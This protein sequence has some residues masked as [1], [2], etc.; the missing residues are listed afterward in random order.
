MVASASVAG[1]FGSARP[2]TFSTRAV[3]NSLPVE[4]LRTVT[5]SG[6]TASASHSMRLRPI[7]TRTLSPALIEFSS[8]IFA[9]PLFPV[10]CVCPHLPLT[11]L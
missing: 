1:G 3:V 7:F 6:P 4:R 8:V 11:R 5:P 2:A 9:A 10:C